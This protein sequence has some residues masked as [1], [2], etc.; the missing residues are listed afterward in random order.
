MINFIEHL[1]EILMIGK[2]KLLA[3]M[4][5][6]PYRYKKYEINKRNGKGK[7]LIAHPS[8]ELKFIQRILVSE[9][10]DILPIHK[11][12]MAYIKGINIKENAETHRKSTYLLKMDFKDYFYSVTPILFFKVLNDL[13]IE[14][15]EENRLALMYLLFFKKN[16]KAKLTLSIGA[17]SS[18]LI[19]NFVMYLFDEYIASYCSIRNINYTRYADDIVFSTNM[20]NSLYEIPEVV[21]I[22]LKN[23]CFNAVKINE[24]KTIFSSKAHNRHITGVTLTNNNKLS[25]GRKRK[26]LISSLVNS[27]RYKTLEKEKISE[28]SGLLSFS[29]YIEPL[30][31]SR[32]KK[33]YGAS[34]IN[35]LMNQ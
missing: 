3:F 28:L 6:S 2:P 16:R 35:E 7:R 19:S 1:D 34:L 10:K 14:L 30:F 18:P 12:A 33:K 27:F 13:K 24:K 31:I 11:S 22:S 15:S 5:T 26:R 9:L 32:L 29:N 8:K 17:P 4:K 21:R 23:Y 20:K 25:L